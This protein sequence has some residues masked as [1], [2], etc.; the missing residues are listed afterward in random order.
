MGSLE[1]VG[2]VGRGEFASLSTKRVVVFPF[3]E[4]NRLL[5]SLSI[6]PLADSRP[7]CNMESN[8]L[9]RHESPRTRRRKRREGS[10]D[11][12]GDEGVRFDSS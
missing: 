8:S 4:S 12:E 9:S 5:T 6:L 3:S 11:H 10:R 1:T 2:G 7:Q